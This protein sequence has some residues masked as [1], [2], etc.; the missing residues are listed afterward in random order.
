MDKIESDEQAKA[1]TA[2]DLPKRQMHQEKW[3]L[4]MPVDQIRN[5]Q[6]ME[7]VYYYYYY[8]YYCGSKVS[9]HWQVMLAREPI[10][11]S[12]IKSLKPLIR[13]L[14]AISAPACRACSLMGAT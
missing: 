1:E 12:M 7:A 13:R 10:E 14:M 9:L 2:S 3:S 11:T 4:R 8:Y 6:R 5:S